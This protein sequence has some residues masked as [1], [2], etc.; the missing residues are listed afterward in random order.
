MAEIDD[1]NLPRQ[2]PERFRAS[3]DPSDEAAFQRLSENDAKQREL[4]ER[5]QAPLNASSPRDVARAKAL[6][7]IKTLFAAGKITDGQRE[8][9]AEAFATI[10]EYDRAAI[11]WPERA[12]L[13]RKYWAAVWLADD[14]WC[15][16]NDSHKYIKE[17]VWSVKED[18]EIPMLA[19]NIC[20]TFNVLDAP[21]H[22]TGRESKQTEMAGQTAGLSIA[23]ALKW[24]QTNVGRPRS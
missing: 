12:D 18:R 21:S 15:E 9:L 24:H 10:G 22:L 13:Y 11:F 19:C 2:L 14:K 8:Q 5:F 7:T 6:T 23:D 20:H 1:D 4:G 3:V 16:H 17:Y